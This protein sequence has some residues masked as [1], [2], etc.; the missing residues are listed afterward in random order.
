MTCDAVIGGAIGGR[1][2]RTA[3]ADAASGE[4]SVPGPADPEPDVFNAPAVADGDGAD[5]GA[6]PAPCR[7]CRAASAAAASALWME[8]HNAKNARQTPTTAAREP[9]LYMP[10]C[11]MNYRGR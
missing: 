1:G 5:G 11:Y 9:C 2:A 6:A 8:C 4:P 7:E 10:G 3:A